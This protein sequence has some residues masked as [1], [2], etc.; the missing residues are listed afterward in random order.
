MGKHLGYYP[1][2]ID[3]FKALLKALKAHYGDAIKFECPLRDGKLLTTV[4]KNAA[5]GKFNGVVNHYHLT[6]RKI[7]CAGLELDEILRELR[8]E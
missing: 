7:D 4:D 5:K 3:A 6:K 2:Q 8:D 1:V